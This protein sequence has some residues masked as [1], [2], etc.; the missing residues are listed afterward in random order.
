MLYFVCLDTHTHTHTHTQFTAGCHY[1]HLR[2]NTALH[3]VSLV[4]LLY[5]QSE[6]VTVQM[7]LYVRPVWPD[8][9]LPRL[10]LELYWH[11]FMH[12]VTDFKWFPLKNSN[13]N[14][15]EAESYCACDHNFF[16]QERRGG[17]GNNITSCLIQGTRETKES[18]R[19][20]LYNSTGDVFKPD[21]WESPDR[22]LPENLNKLQTW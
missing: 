12:D 14:T 4:N 9:P 17:N 8:V 1:S 18:C 22:K 3:F 5:T 13:K 2:G 21:T 20:T 15:P 19:E 11:V 10:H 16:N 6:R 7:F